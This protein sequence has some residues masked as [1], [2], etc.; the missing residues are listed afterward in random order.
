MYDPNTISDKHINIWD[1][2]NEQMFSVLLC[3]L[4]IWK[5]A[6]FIYIYIGG[7]SAAGA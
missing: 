2:F 5:D 3:P 4:S 7:K 6:Y 1:I